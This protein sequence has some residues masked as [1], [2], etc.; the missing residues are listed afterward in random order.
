MNPAATPNTAG[1]PPLSLDSS[2]HPSANGRPSHPPNMQPDP[3]SSSQKEQ[4]VAVAAPRSSSLHH[5]PMGLSL[6]KPTPPLP[7]PEPAVSS[8][9][10]SA[11]AKGLNVA[12]AGGNKLKRAF[13]RR[14]KNSVDMSGVL[15]PRGK[16]LQDPRLRAGVSS[17]SLAT[18]KGLRQP[19]PSSPPIAAAQRSTPPRIES[20]RPPGVISP[21]SANLEVKSGA[22][23]PSPSLAT[24]KSP[25][26]FH[27]TS[28][29]IAT[30]QRSTPPRMETKKPP[31]MPIVLNQTIVLSPTQASPQP[32][33]PPKK[34]SSP[35]P[36]DRSQTS[37]AGSRNSVMPISPGISSA[38]TY[39]SLMDQQ[40]V[41]PAEAEKENVKTP[42]KRDAKENWR[43]SDSTNSHHTIRP[44]GGAGPTSRSSRPVSW[45]ESFQSAHTVVQASTSNR[46]LSALIGDAD[47]GMPEEDDDDTSSSSHAAP[48]SSPPSSVHSRS[49]RSMSL[50]HDS[51]SPSP[52]P[53]LLPIPAIDMKYP[54]HSVSEGHPPFSATLPPR[55]P[56]ISP[57]I[58]QPQSN[59]LRG[60]FAAWTAVAGNAPVTP[61]LTAAHEVSP[62]QQSVAPSSFRQTAISMSAG[63]GPAAAGLAKRAVEKMGRKWA[64]G[65]GISS[66]SSGSGGWSSSSSNDAS[67]MGDALV[68]TSSNTSMS[69]G[70]SSFLHPNPGRVG[71][72]G[73]KRTPGAASISSNSM[74]STSDSDFFANP[75]GPN[76]G[77]RLRGPLRS[78]GGMQMIAG[79]V[80]GR[81]LAAGVKE[82]G[83]RVGKAPQAEGKRKEG[84]VGELEERA[85]AAVVVRCAQHLLLW[86]VQEEGLFRVNGRPT[87][88][89]KLRS[90]FDSG[91][92]Y[93]MTE[94]SPG[95]LDPHAVSSVFKAYLRELPEPILT[96]KL[97]PLFDAAINKET[98]VNA[99]DPTS[100]PARL[101]A[102]GL[103][104]LPSGPKSGFVSGGLRKPPSLSTLAMPSFADIPPASKSLVSAIRALIAQ[105]PAENRDLMLTIVDLVKATAS[106][107]KETK[108]PL[109][110]LM[111]VL[112][113]TLKLTPSLLKVLCETEGIWYPSDVS[114]EEDEEDE[115]IIDIRRQTLTQERRD[116]ED[117][118]S[119]DTRSRLGDESDSLASSRPSLDNPSSDYHGS[120]EGSVYEGQAVPRVLREDYDRSEVPTVYLDSRSH[121]SSTSSVSSLLQDVSRQRHPSDLIGCDTS[122]I[123][124][125]GAYSLHNV[126]LSSSSSPPPL[127]S[128]AESVVTPTSSGNPSFA[129]LPFDAAA[130]THNVS[131]KEAHHHGGS[132]PQI[133]ESTPME[134]RPLQGSKRPVISNPIPIT[135]PVQFP[136]VPS[137]AISSPQAPS[138]P[139]MSANPKRRSIPV[140]SLPSFSPTSPIPFP[141]ASP[142]SAGGVGQALAQEKGLRSKK[143]SLKLLF[144]KK[145]ASS[146]KSGKEHGMSFISTPVLQSQGSRS[147]SDSSV[148]T[149]S[150]AVTAPQ[151]SVSTTP[152]TALLPPVLDTPIED[153]A[154]RLGLGFD[155]SPPDTATLVDS[156]ADNTRRVGE[157]PSDINLQNSP[158]NTTISTSPGTI[159]R[160][161]LS[162]K[163]TIKPGENHLRHQA[164]SSN[165]SIVSTASSHHLSLFEDDDQEN[166]E[167]WTQS[168]L[169]A[170]DMDGKW[171]IQKPNG[172]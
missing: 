27:P 74:G 78:K 19:R 76:L 149:P 47:F 163:R 26:Q 106:R 38:V 10:S 100:A 94:C 31:S 128:S 50:S 42:E 11:A 129:D 145:S 33:T 153:G 116:V 124:S 138:T 52:S 87:H 8:T 101:G 40:L 171:S 148:S 137:P 112:H 109:C 134:L 67:H 143:P 12:V 162:S 139:A 75:T 61:P 4:R 20:T 86:G 53:Q 157:G 111:L 170:A 164:S 64:Q 77:V 63:V 3:S 15:S 16:E 154:L 28:P 51:S 72:G 123:S 167:D 117:D 22:S 98:T 49:H 97:Q 25:R 161:Q 2:F 48:E 115:R 5:H 118:S 58:S 57:S 14:R 55:A 113:P 120:A 102:R 24:E 30:V 141:H 85:L 84:L 6:S 151:S 160:V 35:Q 140:L 39:I 133:V 71:A 9:T 132:G 70:L 146:L 37:Y 54:S 68:R 169:L 7:A 121:L 103:Q 156:Q 32:P 135:T 66:S 83:I 92:D 172:N 88:V 82:T 131:E 119:S 125:G 36:S 45:A 166:V 80:F 122:S 158:Y 43:K 41:K 144:S 56:A 17:P 152:S 104:G 18:D 165:L 44:G 147:G 105:L 110:N 60:R 1:A 29:P 23:S 114:E 13:A 159:Q 34:D 81:D 89:S 136:G 21:T 99:A 150:S 46:R 91:A 73:H 142:Q 96:K 126:P 79:V 62:S 130:M 65:M 93:D 59:T 69:T 107:S 90:E 168:V 108:M 95:D 155:I 127:S